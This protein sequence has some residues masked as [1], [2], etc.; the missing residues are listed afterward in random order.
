MDMTTEGHSECMHLY[1]KWE[2]EFL[3]YRI[4][5]DGLI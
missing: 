1:S 3:G 5:Y 2:S 4:E